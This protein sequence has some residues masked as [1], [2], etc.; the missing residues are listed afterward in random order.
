MEGKIASKIV[1]KRRYEWIDFLRGLSI[2]AIVFCHTV[3]S[4][5]KFVPGLQEWLTMFMIN[6]FFFLSGVLAEEE[7]YSPYQVIKKRMHSLIV[8][9]ILYS[10]VIIAFQVIQCMTKELQLTMLISGVYKTVVLSGIG[11]L[12][13]IPV[14]LGVNILYHCLIVSPN[15]K[16]DFCT[17]RVCLSLFHIRLCT[18]K[19]DRNRYCFRLSMHH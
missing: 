6:I 10:T 2:I 18:K 4:S 9:Y 1:G 17:L 8:P 12:W 7:E 3:K 19:S 11:T 16:N 14:L 15:Q 5:F 13:F